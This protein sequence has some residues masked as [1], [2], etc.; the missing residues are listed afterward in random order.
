M[1]RKAVARETLRIMDQGYYEYKG[2]KISIQSDMDASVDKSRLIT[3]DEGATLLERYGGGTCTKTLEV[4]V[5]NLSTVDAIRKLAQEGRENIGVLN[6]ASAKNPGG[7]F[8]NGA[9]AQEESL[10]AS[11]IL[12]RT[13]TA[14]EA[15]YRNNRAQTSMMYT[16][17]HP[18]PR[19]C[20]RTPRCA[21]CPPRRGRR[22]TG[23]P[24]PPRSPGTGRP[25]FGCPPGQRAPHGR[26]WWRRSP[27][28]WGRGWRWPAPPGRCPS[29]AGWGRR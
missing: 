13:L 25:Y 15:Y 22:R 28:R 16:A 17:V 27:H 4:R 21:G 9:M 14:H 29:A 6:F 26:R 3:P 12:Y 23:W 8:I 5:E 19:T 11:S 7:G 2:Q 18:A 20:G 24:R 1:D 10:A